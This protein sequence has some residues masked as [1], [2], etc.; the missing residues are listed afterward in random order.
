MRQRSRRLPATDR[1]EAILA[2]ATPVFARLGRD[3]ATTKVIADAAGV[4]EALLFKHFGTKD[5]LYTQLERHCVDAHA[6]GAFLL[7]DAVPSTATLVTGVAVLVQAVFSGIGDPQAHDDTK[8]LVTASLLDDGQFAAAFLDRHVRPS[9]DL[10]VD[11][12]VAARA[13]GDREDGAHATRAELW[14][15]HNLANTLH[16]VSLSGADVVNYGMTR[17]ELTAS[18]VL[19]LLRG[20]GL[21]QAAIDRHYDPGKLNSITAQTTETEQ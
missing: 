21:K 2:A 11:C 4:S 18:A 14:F 1:K 8:R 13:A 7:D 5:A 3:G 16:L 6:V 20:L 19:F 17:E 9:I 12:L 10:L 15:V